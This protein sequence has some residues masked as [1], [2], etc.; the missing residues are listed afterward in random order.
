MAGSK[1][2]ENWDK[3]VKAALG[4]TYE[5]ARYH[6]SRDQITGIFRELE[7]GSDPFKSKRMSRHEEMY[8]ELG[9]ISNPI[10]EPYRDETDEMIWKGYATG[11]FMLP[12]N[13]RASKPLSSGQI[14]A[15]FARY[16]SQTTPTDDAK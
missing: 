7:T 10:D 16:K 4:F 15:L 1:V 5:E 6:L 12:K 2:K 3:K 9:V 8:K 11:V 13:M 14:S